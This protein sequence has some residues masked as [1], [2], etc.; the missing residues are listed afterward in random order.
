M[1]VFRPTRVCPGRAGGAATE[2]SRIRPTRM[3]T[4]VR[5]MEEGMRRCNR[6]GEV[7]PLEAFAWH[8][9]SLG[10]RQHHCRECMCAYGREH[11]RANRE[12]YIAAEAR[13]K[14]ARVEERMRYLVD[15]LR[16]HPCVDW[17][18]PIRSFWSSITWEGSVSRLAKASLVA[19]GGASSA[20]SPSATWSAPTATGAEPRAGVDTRVLPF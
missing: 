5:Y 14:R 1:R 4:Y 19:T 7:K 6:C 12:K 15:Y 3:G 8:R 20:R 9:K 18:K 17:G 11:Y 16:S 2:R 10:Q 13:R